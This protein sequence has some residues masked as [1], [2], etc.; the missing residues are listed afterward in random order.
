M[1]NPSYFFRTLFLC[2]AAATPAL[3]A[4]QAPASSAAGAQSDAQC[5][6]AGRVSSDG[7]WAPA[8]SSV[9]LLGATGERIRGANQTTLASVKAVR[10][11]EST[12][13]AQCNA[14]QAMAD[15]LSTNGVKSAV[16]ALKAGDVPIA[17]QAIAMLPGRGLSQWVELRV[18]VPVERVTLLMR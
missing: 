10:L 12:L 8:A 6:L 4:Q 18:A 11:L 17:V 9:H 14:G 2:V 3:Q 13:L 5:I 16:P 15:G 7:R 1:L